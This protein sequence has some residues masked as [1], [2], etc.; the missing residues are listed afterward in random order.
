MKSEIPKERE[1][2][3]QIISSHISKHQ[4]YGSFERKKTLSWEIWRKAESDIF[5]DILFH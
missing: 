2:I 1:W 5:H 3:K 4:K